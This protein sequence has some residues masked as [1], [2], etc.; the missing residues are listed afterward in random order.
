MAK[1]H[2]SGGRSARRGNSPAPYTKQGKVPYRYPWEAR[3]ANG[4]L[5]EAANQ[6]ATNKYR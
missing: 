4:N 3:I 1:R 2:K 6:S 5:R